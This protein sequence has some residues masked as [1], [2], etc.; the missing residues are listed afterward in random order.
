MIDPKNHELLKNEI[1]ARLEEDSNIL[2]Q[3]RDEIRPLKF[4][5]RKIQPRSTTSIALV[6]TDGGNNKLRFDPFL[7]Q[8]IRVV[9]SSNNEYC[10]EAITPT[11][12]TK[13][14]GRSQ[15][16][17]HGKP[18]TPLGQMMKFLGVDSLPALS[19]MIKHQSGNEPDNPNWV[20]V[21]RELME[22]AILFSIMRTKDFATDT[23]IVF[24]G[25]LR[26]KVFHTDKFFKLRQGFKEAIN[27]QKKDYSRSIYLAG[28]AK[29]SKVLERYKLAMALEG[30]LQTRYAA[31]VE[32]P[33][34]IEEK[35]Y[36]WPEYAR[37][38]EKIGKDGKINKFVGGKMFFV[39]FGVA[40]HDPIWP[41]DIFLPQVAEV[42]SI[43]GCMLEDAKNGFPVP[44]YPLCLQKAHNNAA[45]VDFDS[46]I[47]QDEII[48]GI[49]KTLNDEWPALD[50]FM[51]RDSDPTKAR[52]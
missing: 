11:T 47:L 23:L 19:P 50:A 26:S 6:A 35:A 9:D 45:L 8:L 21:Y 30:I 41:I 12:D 39:K 25:L 7:I 32:I 46:D 28:V 34:E 13:K 14:L 15:F 36:I 24:D 17:N 20:K 1:Q 31:Y 2:R 5:V 43:L 48:D 22:W 42:S 52:Y 51:L 49:R 3:L 38:D 10:L 37:D 40:R 18:R 33:R 29:R 27:K 44:L 16:D 4:N